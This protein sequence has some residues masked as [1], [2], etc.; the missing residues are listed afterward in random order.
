[1]VE[2]RSPLSKHTW[3]SVSPQTNLR[4]TSQITRSIFWTLQCPS[5]NRPIVFPLAYTQNRLML[6]SIWAFSH[7]TQGIAKQGFLTAS[8]CGYAGSAVIQTTLC[9]TPEKRQKF[10]QGKI[11]ASHTPKVLLGNS[12]ESHN[13][14]S[15]LWYWPRRSLSHYHLP[16]WWQDLRWHSKTQ[17]GHTGQIVQ[18]Q[19]C[20]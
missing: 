9:I 20:Y 6:I 4:L 11:S 14:Q 2:K 8:S 16:P 15:G 18:Y 19:R 12:F 3:M 13:G 17:L 10:H 5:T 7:V 1:M